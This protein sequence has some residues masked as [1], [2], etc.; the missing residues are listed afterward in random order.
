MK[1]I[2]A[3]LAYRLGGSGA[4]VRTIFVGGGTPTILPTDQ[5]GSLLERVAQLVPLRHVVEFNVEANPATIDDTKAALLSRM[6]VTRVSMGA[7]SFLPSE[8]VALER[9]HQPG[10][11]PPSVEVLRRHHIPQINLDLIYGIPGQTMATWRTSLARAI[12]LDPDHLACYGLMYEPG[13][14]LTAQRKLRLVE[15]CDEALEADMHYAAVDMLVA[16]GFEQYELSNFAKPGCRCQH[17]LGYWR[18][19]PYIGVGPSAAGCTN[20]RRYK[21]V[22]NVN[23]YIRLVDQQRHAEAESETLDRETLM[24]EFILMQLRMVEGISIRSFRE[25]CGADPLTL[26]AEPLA[27]LVELGVVT[28]SKTHIALTSKGQSVADAVMTELA[29][30]IGPHD[31]S[32]PVRSVI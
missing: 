15:P 25:R 16:A 27:R 12:A 8:L 11:I 28:V 29:C 6:G 23:A 2:R 24:T 14:R 5:L 7:Q 13:T 3:E 19:E 31:V 32:L 18:N 21:N 20:N 17:N 4:Q 10:D 1:R 26:F 30:A 22:A 9:I